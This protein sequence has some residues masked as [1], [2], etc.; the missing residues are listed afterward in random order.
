MDGSL[1][2]SA[3]K[4]KQRAIRAGFPETMGLRVHRAISWVGRSEACDGDDDARFLFLWIAFNAAY[5][6]DLGDGDRLHEKQ[7]FG[8]F[9]DKLVELDSADTLYKLIWTEFPGSIRV[10]LKNHYVFEPFWDFNRGKIGEEEWRGPFEWA[11]KASCQAL[12]EHHT[13]AT[14]SIVLARMYT[15]R[16][17]LIHGGSTWG[18]KVNRDQLRD[19]VDFLSKLVPHVIVLMLDNPNTLWGE[20]CYPVVEV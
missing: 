18:S 14:L 6:N 11:N 1:K 7:A 8:Q 13:T 17:Q 15:L 3:L 5:A 16:N 2:F 19:C 12:A 9:L 10:L 4:E 20:A